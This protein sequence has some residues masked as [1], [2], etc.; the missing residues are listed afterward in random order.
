[1][2]S[3]LEEHLQHQTDNSERFFWHRLRWHAVKSYLPESP[4]DLVD[5]GAGAGLLGKFL[6]RDRPNAKYFFVEPIESLHDYLTLT[7]G[8]QSD[9]GGMSDYPS[10]NFVTLL[11]VLE[12]QEDDRLFLRQLTAKMSPGSMLLLTVPALQAL[13][14]PWD[15]ALGHFRRYDKEMLLGAMEGL[16]LK[17]QEM[18]YLFPEM[19]PL[20]RWRARRTNGKPEGD[21]DTDSEFPELPGP[22]NDVLFELGKAT[23][24]MRRHWRK[25]TSLFLAA[26]VT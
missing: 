22:V 16:D 14:S 8:A 7:Y 15:V 1:M 18:S 2:G 9:V 19:V 21:P 17:V 4:I 6:A 3:P 24:A 20:G 11:D 13:W 25:G 12:H 26:T 10:A 5:V 23:L